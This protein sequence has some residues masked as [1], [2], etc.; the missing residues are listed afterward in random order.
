[1]RYHLS[2]SPS[3]SC[4]FTLFLLSPFL[5]LFAGGFSFFH[6]PG[7]HQAWLF[8][9]SLPG[10]LVPLLLSQPSWSSCHVWTPGGSGHDCFSALSG[11]STQVSKSR[12]GPYNE[13][14][15]YFLG[16]L[17]WWLSGKE[18]ACQCR[19]RRLHPWVGKIPLRRK[20]QPT[21]GFLPGKSH[22]QRSLGGYSPWGHIESDTT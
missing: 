6:Y 22:G 3:L 14:S 11:T 16:M 13:E 18:S 19:R 2:F 21:P 5:L 7:P 20:W 10:P 12:T 1:M 15:I 4:P 17:P 8:S 9:R